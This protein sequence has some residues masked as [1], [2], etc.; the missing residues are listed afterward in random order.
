M[1]GLAILE[2]TK[3]SS[4][5]YH[6]LRGEGDGANRPGVVFL[7]GF[8]SDMSGTKAKWLERWCAN[9]GRAYVRFDYRGHGR[10]SGPFETFAISDWAED[11]AA[12]LDRLCDGPQILVG[13]SMGGWIALLLAKRYPDRIA[14]VVGIAAAPD[15][16][17][18]L[19]ETGLTDEEAR[20]LQSSGR[21]VRASAYSEEPHVYTRRLIEDGQRNRVLT[22]PLR[23]T[24]PLRLLHGTDDPDVPVSVSERLL[25]H[26]TCPD[27]MLTVVKGADHR[28]SAPGNL[29]L[30]GSVLEDLPV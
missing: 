2:T 10:S 20:A 13:S 4:I 1:C 14:A 5:A 23:L 29:R 30:L 21:V 3:A 7:C 6:R 16:T 19:L 28:F 18:D 11:A 12:V 24:G 8:R 15:F 26:V 22:T 9:R 25:A 17:Q 27:A